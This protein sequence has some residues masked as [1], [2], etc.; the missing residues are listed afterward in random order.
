[1]GRGCVGGEDFHGVM[2]GAP[3]CWL[4]LCGGEADATSRQM[5]MKV[6]GKAA[7]IKEQVEGKGR[8]IGQI[9]EEEVGG[10]GS[11]KG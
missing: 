9:R 5:G 3:L 4:P 6:N 7:L 2:G 8:N 1:V 11:G 10:G